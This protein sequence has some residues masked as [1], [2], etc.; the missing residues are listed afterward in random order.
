MTAKI[1]AKSGTSLNI[2]KNSLFSQVYSLSSPK[3]IPR[4]FFIFITLEC[5]K[6]F[7][8][9]YFM[10]CYCTIVEY[11]YSSL[12]D[13]L[14]APPQELEKQ[15]KR[16]SVFMSSNWGWGGGGQ[17]IIQ[18]GGV[19]VLNNSTAPPEVVVKEIFVT[20]QSNENKK[21]SL[22]IVLGENKPYTWENI[23]TFYQYWDSWRF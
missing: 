19:T 10:Q 18:T 12:Y 21:K 3:T 11:P 1:P 6:Y 4:L 15:H 8:Y 23:M 5:H 14:A 17:K 16:C 20:F 13:L 7:F 22:G 9:Y 2:G